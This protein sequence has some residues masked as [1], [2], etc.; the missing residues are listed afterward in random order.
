MS[1]QKKILRNLSFVTI[2]EIVSN[3]LSYFLIILIARKLGTEGLGIYSFAFAFVGLF[4]VLND[5]GLSTFFVRE[6]AKKKEDVVNYFGNY[7]AMRLI[8]CIL[9][10]LL[11]L[12]IILFL[13]RSHEVIVVVYLASFI[14]F[15]QTY[16]YV[17][18]NAFLAFQEMKYD[19]I[20]KVAERVFAFILGIYALLAGY[21]L[22][23]FLAALAISN[24][25]ALAISIL[26]LKKISVGFRL[27]FD[28]KLWKSMIYASWPFWLTWVFLQIYF[29]ID[30]VML[31]FIKGYEATGIYNAA[32]KL[33]FVIDK[34]PLAVGMVLFPVMSELHASSKKLLKRTLEKGMHLLS[35]ISFPIA[36]GIT[37][38]SSRIILFIY[39]S[40]FE[41]ST[42]TLQILIWT[43]IFMFFSYLIGWFLNAIDKQKVFAYS[44]G[45]C[46]LMNVILNALLI[47]K[48][49]YIG[50]SAATLAT[51][52][53]NFAVLYYFT[54]KAGYF[55]N[56]LRFAIRPVI[57]SALMALFIVF[58]GGS[59]HIIA[60]IPIAALIYLLLLALMGD[61]KREDF[62]SIF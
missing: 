35:I 60:L 54:V 38:I 3:L 16:S 32:Y 46:L 7:A 21:G 42:I 57:A 2:G 53:L 24:L 58:F 29:Q 14:F 4:A 40:G 48:F 8:L 27:R 11:P 20:V 47:P 1:L 56:I 13:K 50:A 41:K 39:K 17:P 37:V 18:R 6:V 31:S 5:F 19:S 51:A 28:Y 55:D 12:V 26:L 49:S 61:I 44:T 45:F 43:T 25:I 62:Q 33:I 36:A 15:M 9:S 52:A 59:V 23:G 22:V 10:L 30:T 34:I